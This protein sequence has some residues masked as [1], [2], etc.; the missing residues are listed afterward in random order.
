[1]MNHTKYEIILQLSK[2][3]NHL[4]PTKD[5]FCT[6]ETQ[7]GHE[8]EISIFKASFF[9]SIAADKEKKIIYTQ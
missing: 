2:L 4:P 3:R 7:R 9:S 6:Q 5:F 1:M 8:G